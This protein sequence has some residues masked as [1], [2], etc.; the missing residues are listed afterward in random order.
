[1][2]GDGTGLWKLCRYLTPHLKLATELLW[3]N[4]RLLMVLLI[5][6]KAG[7]MVA[8]PNCSTL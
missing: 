7:H 1:M 8:K 6:K 3:P 2:N 4:A 5:A